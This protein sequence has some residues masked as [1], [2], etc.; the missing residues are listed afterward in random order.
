MST[1]SG[2]FTH[3]NE[4]FVCEYCGRHVQKA[5][6]GCRNHCPFCL[7][8]KHVD[9]NPGDRANECRGQLKANGYE[10]DG[11]KG[12]VL[13]FLCQKCGQKTRNKSLRDG[14]DPDDYDLI[15]KLNVR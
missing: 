5:K 4:N 8:S 9:I 13:L 12:I 15:L 10:L 6:T 14:P 2:Q 11:K 1:S 3:I 7:S